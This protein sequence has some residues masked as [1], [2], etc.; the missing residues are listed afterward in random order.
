M[1]TMRK[2][3]AISF[4]LLTTSLAQA[5]SSPPSFC[6]DGNVIFQATDYDLHRG[7]VECKT[8]NGDPV[9][10]DYMQDGE[11]RLEMTARFSTS[12]VARQRFAETSKLMS[13]YCLNQK[14]R[15]FEDR[16]QTLYSISARCLTQNIDY[17]IQAGL[18]G[19]DDDPRIITITGTST[20]RKVSLTDELV[21]KVVTVES[22]K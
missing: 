1:K 6:L 7:R 4:L 2:I 22:V 10:V 8:D 13:A 20:P 14:N 21:G 12:K 9:T 11:R 19:S 3:T 18:V 17:D 16:G 15:I 5:D